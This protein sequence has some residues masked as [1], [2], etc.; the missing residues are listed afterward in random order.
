MA[1]DKVIIHYKE[2][3][4]ELHFD[5]FDAVVDIDDLTKIDYSN[6]YGELLTVPALMN[7]VGLWKA[8]A[9]N[10]VAEARLNRDITRAQLSQKYRNSLVKKD[11][12]ANGKERVKYPSNDEVEH[13]VVLDDTYQVAQRN[14]IRKQKEA[15]VLDSLYWAVKSK[16]KKLDKIGEKMNLQ[17][18]EFEK[19]I[20]EGKYNGILVKAKENAIK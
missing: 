9:D 19:H 17:P 1:R 15:D 18:E 11:T 16:E 10:A 7:R 12:Y 6:L 8:E 3:H 13:A 20:V 5:Q 4:I 2:R 14:R